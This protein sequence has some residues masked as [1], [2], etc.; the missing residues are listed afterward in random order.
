MLRKWRLS[1]TSDASMNR[2]V[3]KNITVD[4][5]IFFAFIALIYLKKIIFF[6]TLNTN[7]RTIIN[8]LH[9]YQNLWTAVD[10]H[11]TNQFASDMEIRW[12][13]QS[14]INGDRNEL[15]AELIPKSIHRVY[16]RLEARN[17]LHCIAGNN[18]RV[19]LICSVLL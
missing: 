18:I 19:C 6:K 10:T 9:A 8:N 16:T 15:D 4:T 12:S 14:G 13:L 3:N 11:N 1:W 2:I 17:I 5:I 7:F